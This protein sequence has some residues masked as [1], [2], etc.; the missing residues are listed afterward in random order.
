MK[1]SWSTDG[2]ELSG[3]KYS[4]AEIPTSIHGRRATAARAARPSTHYQSKRQNRARAAIKK[5]DRITIGAKWDPNPAAKN[6]GRCRSQRVRPVRF[7]PNTGD[8]GVQ[9]TANNELR[10]DANLAGALI[11][12]RSV[13]E[14]PT[15][16]KIYFCTRAS[17]SKYAE[18]WAGK[19]WT[20]LELMEV[21]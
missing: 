3:A 18:R 16:P 1:A 19:V 20:N 4:G 17:A 9:V 5:G 21:R 15:R 7:G 6:V 2:T 8:R 14:S 11:T 10:N 13:L 12:P